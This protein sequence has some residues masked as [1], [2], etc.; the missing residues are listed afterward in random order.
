MNGIMNTRCFLS[1]KLASMPTCRKQENNF[2]NI[3]IISFL[4]GNMQASCSVI[5]IVTTQNTHLND[6]LAPATFY[7]CPFFNLHSTSPP[8]NQH[9]H[10]IYNFIYLFSLF[11]QQLLR[12]NSP[13]TP[14][15][16]L[17]GSLVFAHNIFLMDHRVVQ[18][19]LVIVKT[20]KAHFS[21]V[22][23]YDTIIT[24][25]LPTLSASYTNNKF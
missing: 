7:F 19:K 6:Y 21:L 9:V 18:K 23:C 10:I 20:C 22:L 15:L 13:H 14:F 16:F 25:L 1:A 5:A 12:T 8:T 2:M 17:L 3:A 11:F 4:M 24:G